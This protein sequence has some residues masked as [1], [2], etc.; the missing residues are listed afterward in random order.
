MLRP[1]RPHAALL[2]LILLTACGGDTNN[3]SRDLPPPD[4]NVILIV[5][6]TMGARYLGCHTPGLTNS[7]TIDRLA[8]TGVRFQRAYSVAPWTQPAVASLFTSQMPSRHGVRHIF[9]NLDRRHQTL[10]ERLKDRG[11]RT[12]GVISHFVIGDEFGYGQGFDEYRDDPV[13]NHRSVTSHD[14]TDV[15]ISFLDGVADD[16]FFMFVHYFDPHWYF[17]HHPDFDQTAGYTGDLLPGME[18]GALRAMRGD[19]TDD[20]IG[21]LAGLYREEIAYT[22]HHIARLLDHLDARGLTDDTVVI[23]TADHGEEFMQHGW[24]GHTATLY[25]E[26]VHVPLIVHAP[27]RIAPRVVD[28]PVSIMD[29][30]PTILEL[31]GV[32]PDDADWDGV[33]LAPVLTAGQPAPT[34]P[35]LAE[36][37]YISPSG[38][39]S[40]DRGTKRYYKTA[41]IDGDL[42]LVHDFA[43]G[44]WE[45]Y[46]RAADPLEQH[47]LWNPEQNERR[48][49]LDRLHVW[50]VDHTGSWTEELRE[51]LD[52]DPDAVKRLRALGYV[53]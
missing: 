10:A 33:S 44:R 12:F 16:R 40:G 53:H 26:L 1:F 38:W 31:L 46:D 36:V 7:P 23:V 24:I 17:N 52:I 28:T 34:R 27:G 14:V 49:L 5:V 47:N 35:L 20:D 25:D 6:D 43:D 42:K 39:P 13:G 22:D 11:L 45:V 30:G 19:L 4:L 9:H 32:V 37:S 3:S 29:I 15:A 21:Y 18:I 2:L 8:T 48:A 51:E 50:E 41:I